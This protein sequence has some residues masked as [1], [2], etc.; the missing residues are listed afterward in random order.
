MLIVLWGSKGFLNWIP[1]RQYL[2]LVYRIMMRK[3]LN[4]DQP[5]SFNEK[6]Q[7]LKLN[8][9]NP[10]YSAYVDKYEVR[11]HIEETLGTQ[12]LVPLIKVFDSVEQVDWDSLPTKFA[13]KC[14][15][16][17]GTN[18][19]CTDKGKLDIPSSRVKLRKWLGTNWY[20]YGREWPYKYIKPRI[21]CENFISDLE[22]SPDDYKVLCFNG[23]AKLIEV[24]LDR[25]GNHQQDYYD[26]EWNK[27]GISQEGTRSDITKNRPPQLE[28]M[29]QL[30]ERLAAPMRHVRIDWFIVK[31]QLYFSEITFYDASGFVPFDNEADDF[32]LGSWLDLKEAKQCRNH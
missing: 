19:I 3:P 6:L 30:S 12:Y 32:L 20:W 25:H 9:R 13:L 7:W 8:D 4:I 29:I 24:H 2:Q 1:D 31:E 15:H 17:S 5:A 18:I 11:A 10:A 28:R 21:I 22:K 23:K 16:G 26:L 14:T 27:T